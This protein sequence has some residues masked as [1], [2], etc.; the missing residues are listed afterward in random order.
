[1]S[2]CHSLLLESSQ[3]LVAQVSHCSVV[4]ATLAVVA[5]RAGPGWCG[6][7]DVKLDDMMLNV[8]GLRLATP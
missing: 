6:I 8:K 5:G 2:R 7:A 3:R 1:M 4:V